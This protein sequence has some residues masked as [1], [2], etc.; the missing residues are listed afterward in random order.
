MRL[1]NQE[2]FIPQKISPGAGIVDADPPALSE[3]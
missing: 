3:L 1:D 2:E